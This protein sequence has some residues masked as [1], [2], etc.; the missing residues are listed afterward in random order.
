[1]KWLCWFRHKWGE[2]DYMRPTEAGNGSIF[3]LCM[4]R[5]GF[6]RRRC[7]RCGREQTGFSGVPNSPAP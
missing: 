2:W 5:V 4:T 7:L 1:M 6:R 3:V